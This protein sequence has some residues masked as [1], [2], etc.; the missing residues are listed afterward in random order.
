MGL[1][2]LVRPSSV[3]CTAPTAHTIKQLHQSY[4]RPQATF[5]R[6]NLK[7]YQRSPGVKALR[8]AVCVSYF[9][10][11]CWLWQSEGLLVRSTLHRVQSPVPCFRCPFV[12]DV[13]RPKPVSKCA[14]AS[15][16]VHNQ[17]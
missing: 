11:S 17:W 3:C 12:A 4:D 5:V 6:V 10:K 9:M 16:P 14:V 7:V 1:T 8:L 15:E 13:I 2:L